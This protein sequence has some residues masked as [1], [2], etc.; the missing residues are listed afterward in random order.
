VIGKFPENK[1][2][3]YDNSSHFWFLEQRFHNETTNADNTD[4]LAHIQLSSFKDPVK[5]R[6][7]TKKK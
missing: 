2:H 7:Q 1:A 3:P 5:T 6:K 4:N